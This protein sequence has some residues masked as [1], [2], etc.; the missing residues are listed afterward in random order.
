[1]AKQCFVRS[2]YV[3]VT[4]DNPSIDGHHG[5]DA[6]ATGSDISEFLRR[7]HGAAEANGLTIWPTQ[8]N[9]GFLLDTGFT[10]DDI[11][12]L[13][14]ALKPRD[15]SSG[16]QAD[17]SN[18]R[19]AGEVWKFYKEHAGYELYVKLKLHHGAPVAECMSCHEADGE[20]RR[21]S[22]PRR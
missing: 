13:V 12:A 15:Y 1:V 2:W 5:I 7:F 14:K 4:L 11:V 3:R 19:P 8:K 16:P 22:R 9:N 18:A 10:N 17:D 20:M 21:P 6:V